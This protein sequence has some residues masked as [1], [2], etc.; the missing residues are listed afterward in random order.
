MPTSISTPMS[1]ITLSVVPVS[2]STI[3]TPMNPMGT[4]SMIC[5]G[6]LKELNCATRMR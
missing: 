2:G 4:A 5:K 6:S 3:I 1:D